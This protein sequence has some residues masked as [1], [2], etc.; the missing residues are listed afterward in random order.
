MNGTTE[1]PI[2]YWHDSGNGDRF[3]VDPSDFASSKSCEHCRPVYGADV[4]DR[5][6]AR[7]AELEAA[8]FEAVSSM[9]E[10]R[11]KARAFR[12]YLVSEIADRTEGENSEIRHATAESRINQFEAELD[13][14][15]AKDGA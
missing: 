5:L 6:R 15:A 9:Q 2:F 13:A 1:H 11:I 14:S 3:R 7:V 8:L 12:N 4:V 10:Y